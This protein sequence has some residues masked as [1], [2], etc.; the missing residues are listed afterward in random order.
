MKKK[1]WDSRLEKDVS[2]PIW[3]KWGPHS[4]A[5]VYFASWG[6][7]PYHKRRC[8]PVF[9]SE[10]SPRHTIALISV[11]KTQIIQGRLYC[12]LSGSFFFPC[13]NI[14][15]I[16]KI[17]LCHWSFCSWLN[18]KN[19]QQDFITHTHS[20]EGLCIHTESS[21]HPTVEIPEKWK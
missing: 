16:Q 12:R 3:G 5:S 1:A 18:L 7:G 17:K 15:H 10:A 21:E 13:F 6:R 9:N 8:F 11:W 2:W 4:R 20:G 14:L 19:H